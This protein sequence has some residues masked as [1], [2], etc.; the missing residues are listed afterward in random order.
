MVNESRFSSPPKGMGKFMLLCLGTRI[1]L[2]ADWHSRP[3]VVWQRLATLFAIGCLLSVLG[4]WVMANLAAIS[5]S[6]VN[7]YI[8]PVSLYSDIWLPFVAVIAVPI[9]ALFA[10]FMLLAHYF[11]LAVQRILCVKSDGSFRALPDE[12]HAETAKALRE[13]TYHKVIFAEPACNDESKETDR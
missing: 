10:A 1:L 2:K 4:P 3:A 7:A 5:R 8:S 11:V 9:S 13:N 6:G 12:A